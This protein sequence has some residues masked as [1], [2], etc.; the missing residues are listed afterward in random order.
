MV[1]K[2]GQKK[3]HKPKYI[4]GLL[5]GQ[6]AEKESCVVH[7]FLFSGGPVL[8][9]AIAPELFV[10]SSGALSPRHTNINPPAADP[11]QGTKAMLQ[12]GEKGG[13][14]RNPKYRVL[15]FMWCRALVSCLPHPL[16]SHPLI[17]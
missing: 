13:L 1:G 3:R 7:F 5:I 8:F 6:N 2:R 4:R 16:A 14:K 15:R 10:L 17:Q 9:G 12:K 11:A